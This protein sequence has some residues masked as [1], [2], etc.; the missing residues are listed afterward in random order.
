MNAAHPVSEV[1]AM[2]ICAPIPVVRIQ[3]DARQKLP[4]ARRAIFCR[5]S[6]ERNDRK[7]AIMTRQK[8]I[9]SP[10]SLVNPAGMRSTAARKRLR[11]DG[12]VCSPFG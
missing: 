12:I 9:V 11:M 4:L 2:L 8:W 5:P 7:P 3:I 6:V 1:A 10:S